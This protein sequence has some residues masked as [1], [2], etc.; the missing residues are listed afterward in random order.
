MHLGNF[1]LF[2]PPYFISYFIPYFISFNS[3][4]VGGSILLVE[5]FIYS[6]LHLYCIGLKA[7]SVN[8]EVD[9][10]KNYAN[11]SISEDYRSKKAT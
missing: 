6:F 8:L 1:K 3:F 4:L 10:M 9:N 5:L 11:F 2:P 7:E